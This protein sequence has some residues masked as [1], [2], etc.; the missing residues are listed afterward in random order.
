MIWTN[1]QDGWLPKWGRDERISSEMSSMSAMSDTQ[2]DCQR[3]GPR[4]AEIQG[5]V[6]E[7]WCSS[8]WLWCIY[9]TMF[10]FAVEERSSCQKQVPLFGE[11]DIMICT[12]MILSRI[13]LERG[14]FSFELSRIL[15]FCCK[16][17]GLW[18]HRAK[19]GGL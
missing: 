3:L 9:I 18:F 15:H 4:G 5:I 12:R 19:L 2:L 7:S 8:C 6:G 16:W 11:P 14:M 1:L 17:P 10:L 13:N